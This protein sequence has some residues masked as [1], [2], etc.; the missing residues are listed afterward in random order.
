MRRTTS[1]QGACSWINLFNIKQWNIQVQNNKTLLL[2]S[3]EWRDLFVFRVWVVDVF[4]VVEGMFY[5]PSVLKRTMFL[6]FRHRVWP[7]I[8]LSIFNDKISHNK[9]NDIYT[10]ILNKID[11]QTWCLKVKNVILFGMKGVY[12]MGHESINCANCIINK[13]LLKYI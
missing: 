4:G 3:I 6:T 11:G 1:Y 9:I 8:L 7:S 5:I 12:V 10:N 13:L 2:Y